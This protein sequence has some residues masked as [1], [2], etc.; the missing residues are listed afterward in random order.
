MSKSA[1]SSWKAC[2]TRSVCRPGFPHR[3]VAP[4][5]TLDDARLRFFDARASRA[6]CHLPHAGV[7]KPEVSEVRRARPSSTPAFS[8]S[9][10]NVTVIVLI[11][12][13]A[14]KVGIFCA[15]SDHSRRQK[16]QGDG[17]AAP[18]VGRAVLSFS[19]DKGLRIRDFD[20]YS[21]RVTKGL[22]HEAE[23]ALCRQRLSALPGRFDEQVRSACQG[24]K[25]NRDRHASFPVEHCA[26]C[27]FPHGLIIVNDCPTRAR[28]DSVS[29]NLTTAPPREQPT[30]VVA[31]RRRAAGAPARLGVGT[32]LRSAAPQPGVR[33]FSVRQPCQ[34]LKRFDQPRSDSLALLHQASDS[35]RPN[36]T[37]VPW[38]LTIPREARS[39]GRV[40]RPTLRT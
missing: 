30:R 16:M 8:S 39:C 24:R 7:S 5:R 11:G 33:L 25:L 18:D 38:C 36:A 10:E 26:Q 13:L 21:A 22:D 9:R 40:Q 27:R 20:G 23:S 28:E 6:L 32:A 29:V 1:T 4:F 19:A 14:G 31:S 15:T 17:R 34:R 2:E 12:I 37:C 3:L 35:G